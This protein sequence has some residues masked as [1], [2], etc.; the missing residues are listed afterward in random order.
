M[1]GE[2]EQRARRE[3]GEHGIPVPEATWE[4]IQQ[5]AR[6]RSVALE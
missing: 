4:A 1:P 2:P 3:R 5:A 6:E